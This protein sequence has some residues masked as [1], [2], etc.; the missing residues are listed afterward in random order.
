MYSKEASVQFTQTVEVN[1][2]AMKLAPAEKG[3]YFLE[4]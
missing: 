2:P 4:M 1:G 3:T